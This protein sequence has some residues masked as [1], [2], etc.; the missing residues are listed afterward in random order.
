MPRTD[1]RIKQDVEKVAFQYHLADVSEPTYLYKKAQSLNESGARNLK[2]FTTLPHKDKKYSNYDDFY[3]HL[4]QICD[5]S[6]SLASALSCYVA[7]AILAG[8]DGLGKAAGAFIK[9]KQAPS[10][11]IFSKEDT[12]T[13]HIQDGKLDLS[14]KKDGKFLV[15]DELLT[16]AK[17]LLQDY[18][19]HNNYK[20]NQQGQ[21]TY[22][23]NH[24]KATPPNATVQAGEI[25]H[26]ED[27]EKAVKGNAEDFRAYVTY[28]K[29]NSTPSTGP[30]IR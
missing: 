4:M 7:S 30:T 10:N 15:A 11:N 3:A 27:F 26:A 14:V 21:V 6:E 16:P 9:S 1:P 28:A 19:E 23:P 2:H 5:T 29:E 25:I 17:D 12:F 18:F 13:I 20:I 24:P 8:V 22:G